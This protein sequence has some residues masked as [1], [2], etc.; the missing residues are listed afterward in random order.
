[1]E[2]RAT[3]NIFDV[4]INEKKNDSIISRKRKEKKT[5]R[6]RKNESKEKEKII[7]Y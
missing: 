4:R 5:Q 3:V 1:M 2:K 7:Y 6:R